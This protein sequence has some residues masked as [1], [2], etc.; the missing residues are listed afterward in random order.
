MLTHDDVRRLVGRRKDQAA[1]AD[2]ALAPGDGIPA[3]DLAAAA[4][5]LD[6][7]GA[8]LGKLAA[9]LAVPSRPEG[10]TA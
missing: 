1:R 9:R 4:A 3:L 8:K 5:E 10:V 2:K 6:K 7:M